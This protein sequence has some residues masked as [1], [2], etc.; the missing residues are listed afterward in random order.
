[1]EGMNEATIANDQA[2]ANL[3]FSHKMKYGHRE[4]A[5]GIDKLGII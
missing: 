5:K 4:L 3:Q 2:S 1:M